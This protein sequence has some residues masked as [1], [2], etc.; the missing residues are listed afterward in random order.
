MLSKRLTEIDVSIILA[1]LQCKVFSLPFLFFLKCLFNSVFG[2]CLVLVKV[3]EFVNCR[4][5]DKISL[6]VLFLT[7]C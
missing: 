2:L 3:A 7:D 6:P 4:G 1:V 5:L